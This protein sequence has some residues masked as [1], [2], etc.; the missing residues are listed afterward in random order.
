MKICRFCGE[1]V[2]DTATR[3]ESCGHDP[4]VRVERPSPVPSP[5][6]RVAPPAEPA[7]RALLAPEPAPIAITRV[8]VVDINMPFASMVGFIVKWTLAAI[9]ALFILAVIGFFLAVFLGGLAKGITGGR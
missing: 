8:S 1:D 6:A 2:P 5:P 9:P 4:N 3:C 7:G